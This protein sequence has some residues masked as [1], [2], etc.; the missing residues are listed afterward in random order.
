MW[1]FSAKLTK[2]KAVAIVLLGG[3]V[4]CG[5][6]FA[7][8]Q[9][10]RS[11]L[12]PDGQNVSDNAARTAY[13]AAWGWEVDPAA[14]ET[15]DLVLPAGEDASFESFNELQKEIGMDLAPYRGQRLRRYTYTVRNYPGRP[16]GVQADLYLCGDTV[17]A[18]VIL[19]T[20]EDAFMSSLRY[21]K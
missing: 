9:L 21:P 18:G 17:V 8:H 2:A 16:E 1:I 13:L 6:I 12:P 4:L 5:L 3:A 19:S 15:L 11:A 14:T 10:Q 7:A 20:G